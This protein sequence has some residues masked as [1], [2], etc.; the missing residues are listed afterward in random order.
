V[1]RP[2]LALDFDGVVADTNTL[3][4]RWIEEHLGL[5]VAVAQ[6]NRT[7][8][9]PLIG[10]SAYARMSDFVYGEVSTA[11]VPAVPGAL[12]AIEDLAEVWRFVLITARPGRRFQSALEWLRDHGLEPCFAEAIGGGT[13]MPKKQ[14]AASRGAV[15]LVDDDERHLRDGGD[16][17]FRRVLF[18]QGLEREDSRSWA[19]GE[20]TVVTSWPALTGLLRGLTGDVG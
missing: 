19:E 11:K 2:I 8:C 18:S 13:G 4:S 14:I 1:S 20:L 12:K 15:G 5:K 16:P 17:S 10:E 7:A 3:K 9:V 6:C